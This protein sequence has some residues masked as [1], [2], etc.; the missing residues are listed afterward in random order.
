[1]LKFVFWKWTCLRFD[2]SLALGA[3]CRPGLVFGTGV[4]RYSFHTAVEEYYE[5]EFFRKSQK[6]VRMF[7]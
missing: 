3:V 5:C 2:A 7:R 6:S 4:L 1:M